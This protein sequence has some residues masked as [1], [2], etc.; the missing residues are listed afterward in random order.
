ML[1]TR[2]KTAA[3]SPFASVLFCVLSLGLVFLLGQDFFPQ[4]MLA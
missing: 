1:E 2:S 3:S 4:V